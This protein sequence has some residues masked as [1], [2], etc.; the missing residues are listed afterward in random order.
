[1]DERGLEVIGKQN[2]I[3]TGDSLSRFSAEN[4]GF[5]AFAIGIIVYTSRRTFG[6]S[7]DHVL[8][9]H[10]SDL[11]WQSRVEGLVLHNR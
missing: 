3:Q 5:R 6:D 4:E 11:E 7:L 1:M 2:Q 10:F 8:P 9:D